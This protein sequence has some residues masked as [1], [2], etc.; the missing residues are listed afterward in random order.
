M[1]RTQIHSQVKHTPNSPL[2]LLCDALVPIC[3]QA[4]LVYQRQ[5]AQRGP[6][7]HRA[8][9]VDAAGVLAIKRG[10]ARVVCAVCERS[11]RFKGLQR[12]N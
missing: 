4:A 1:T 9:A 6:E 12:A 11:G 3:V 7:A 8:A 2:E 10:T 5:G